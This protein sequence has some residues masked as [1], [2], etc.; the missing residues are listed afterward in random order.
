MHDWT[1]ID[2]SNVFVT[3]RNISKSMRDHS[4]CKVM[5]DQVIC[6]K[7]YGAAIRNRQ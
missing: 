7:T 4:K 5:L 3:D 1:I 6:I 2:R